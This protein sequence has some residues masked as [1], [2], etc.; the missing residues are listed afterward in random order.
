MWVCMYPSDG[1]IAAGHPALVQQAVA[2]TQASMRA[3][4]V[5]AQDQIAELMADYS[6]EKS[7]NMAELLGQMR[8]SHLKIY[9]QEGVDL[10]FEGHPAVRMLNLTAHLSAD[11]RFESFGFD[12]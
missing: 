2:W 10:I 9:E 3:E 8:L 12:G 7:A 5:A 4:L 6:M 11:L 1:E